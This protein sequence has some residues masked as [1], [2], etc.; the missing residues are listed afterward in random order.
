M[1][2]KNK[3]ECSRKVELEG[4]DGI[5]EEMDE[6]NVWMRR[7]KKFSVPLRDSCTYQLTF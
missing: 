4:A 2:E 1:D 3:Q 6:M 5:G 7:I